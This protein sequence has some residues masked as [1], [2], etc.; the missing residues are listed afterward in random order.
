MAGAVHGFQRVNAVVLSFGLLAGRT[1]HEHALAIPTPVTGDLPQVLVK[2][3]RRVDLLIAGGKAPAH[4]GD[5][6]LEQ[7]PAFWMPEDRARPFFLSVE[8]IHL[9]REFAMIAPL[10]LLKLL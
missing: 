7:G 9:A 8:P 10:G 4:V 1:A 6:N 3:L 5:Q 2:H